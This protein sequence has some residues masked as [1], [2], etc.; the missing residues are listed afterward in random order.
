LHENRL[1]IIKL[2]DAKRRAYLANGRVPRSSWFGG[3]GRDNRNSDPNRH[4]WFGGGSNNS[5]GLPLPV[6][7][8]NVVVPPPPV[9]NDNTI[10]PPV[11]VPNNDNVVPPPLP[12]PPNPP[13]GEEDTVVIQNPTDSQNEEALERL[14]SQIERYK[15]LLF[16]M[17]Q[18]HLLQNVGTIYRKHRE[19]PVVQAFKIWAL[20]VKIETARLKQNKVVGCLLVPAFL[21]LSPA[22]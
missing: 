13:S 8:S 12:V 15:Y 19:M 10:I 9:P 7:N 1:K 3:F 4:G 22:T 2:E 5:G 14:E 17:E 21:S 18:D 16:T 20:A 11:P 6:P